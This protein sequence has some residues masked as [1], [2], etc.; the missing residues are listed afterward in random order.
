MSQ[1]TERTATLRTDRNAIKIINQADLRYSSVSGA[2]S[3][4]VSRSLI[5]GSLGR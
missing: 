5:H 1:T 4:K 2:T 3:R